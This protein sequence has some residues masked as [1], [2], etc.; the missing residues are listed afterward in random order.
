MTIVIIIFLSL[1]FCNSQYTRFTFITAVR[2]IAKRR[3][4]LKAGEKKT[5]VEVK[6][7]NT[8]K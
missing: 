8:N 3:Y 4:C 7:V 6:Q 5:Q 1:W 2:A